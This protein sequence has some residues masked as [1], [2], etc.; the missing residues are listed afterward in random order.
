MRLEN[1]VRDLNLRFDAKAAHLF[2]RLALA[3]DDV[4][5]LH[6]VA[7]IHEIATCEKPTEPFSYHE[8]STVDEFG[9]GEPYQID[10]VNVERGSEEERI[11]AKVRN[12]DICFPRADTI[13]IPKVR[14][15]LG[16][17]VLVRDNNR[18]YYTRAFLEAVPKGISAELLYCVLKHPLVLWQI[19]RIATIGKG[20]P[21]ISP[22]DLTRFV[23]V[24]SRLIGVASETDR[25]IGEELHILLD[26]L[27]G[28][29]DERQIIDAVLK[30]CLDNSTDLS[31][32]AKSFTCSHSRLG[33]SFD[34]R[35][36][37]HFV[38]PDNVHRI[39]HLRQFDTVKI[40]ALC[41]VPICLGVSPELNI[42]ESEYRYLGSQAMTAERLYPEKLGFVS[43]EYYRAMVPHFGVNYGDVFVRRS[44]ASL[45]KVLYFDSD[46]P[47]IFSDFMMRIRFRELILGKFTAYWMRSTLFQNYIKATAIV[48]KG[49]QNIYPYQVAIMPVLNPN[50]YDILHFV[51]AIDIEMS[52]NDQTRAE[53]KN[54]MSSLEER[55]SLELDF[56][57]LG[58]LLLG[59]R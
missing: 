15:H 44:G 55:L 10:E 53:V 16:K 25:T 11:L 52:R 22:F 3:H 37:A 24:P 1:I 8:I 32:P 31:L 58:E 12:G 42:D 50:K 26:I 34:L 46:I 33:M 23:R 38:Q 57:G 20:Y 9:S 43:E 19:N 6:A 49:L 29:R 28:L 40:I 51:E 56:A 35:F 4:V 18:T 14:P 21:T 41:A 7:Q 36:S 30:E 45:G 13:L 39:E 2:S 17:F 54:R 48:G 47:C 59:H 5:P 27:S